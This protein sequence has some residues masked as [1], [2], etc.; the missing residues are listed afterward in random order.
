[1]KALAAFLA[2]ILVVVVGYLTMTFG[3][4]LSVASWPWYIGGT[5][6]SMTLLVITSALK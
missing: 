1:M 4:G 3:W 6:T 2:W 5:L